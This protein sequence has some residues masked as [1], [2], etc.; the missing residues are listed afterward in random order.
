MTG[1]VLEAAETGD[2]RAILVALRNKLAASLDETDYSRDVATLAKRLMD[3]CAELDSM[4]SDDHSNPLQ[5]ARRLYGR[6]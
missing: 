1:T 6:G 5:E 3:V 4:P 2:R